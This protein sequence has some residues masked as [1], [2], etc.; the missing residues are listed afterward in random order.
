VSAASSRPQPLGLDEFLYVMSRELGVAREQVSPASRLVEDLGLDSLGIVELIVALEGMGGSLPPDAFDEPVD[1]SEIYYWY[2]STLEG[3]RW[4]TTPNGRTSR[5]SEHVA[6][7][8]GASARGPRVLLRPLREDDHEALRGLATSEEGGFRWRLRALA[9]GEPEFRRL[10]WESVLVQFVIA[11]ADAHDPLGLVQALRA[12]PQG[13]AFLT[14]LVDPRRQGRGLGF[15]ALAIFVDYLFDN[16]PLRRLYAEA[17]SFDEDVF[18]GGSGRLFEE[19][20]RMPDQLF[21]RGRR[22]DTLIFGVER[23]AWTAGAGERLRAGGTRR[24]RMELG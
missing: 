2:G 17:G 3:R 8:L 22:W 1:F 18:R 6:T 15:E 11:R 4:D 24:S 14:V 10:L 12:S 7:G 23:T 19:H 5:C 9:P 16:F 13:H 21:W 20:A